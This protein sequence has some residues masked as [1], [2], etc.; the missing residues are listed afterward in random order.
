[1]ISCRTIASIM[2]LMTAILL[3]AETLEK[4][5]KDLS[6]TQGK[7]RIT[8]LGKIFQASQE[9]QRPLAEQWQY[10]SDLIEEAQRQH[11]T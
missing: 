6:T 4:F 1:M 9:E 8:M 2:L 7:D 5:K 11:D 10:A 3:P